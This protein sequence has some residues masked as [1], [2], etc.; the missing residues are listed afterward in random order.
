MKQNNLWKLF[1]VLFV[2]AWS[3]YELYPPT[4]QSLIDVFERK[5]VAVDTNFTAIV[6]QAKTLQQQSPKTP[7]ENLLT[8]I[9][10]RTT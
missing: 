7:F 4:S 9:N 3:L 10:S 5:A 6:Q 8:A 2:V 1:L